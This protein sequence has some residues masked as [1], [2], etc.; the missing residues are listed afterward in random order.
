MEC[1]ST[2]LKPADHFNTWPGENVFGVG[3]VGEFAG[4]ILTGEMQVLVHLQPPFGAIGHI[5]DETF[6]GNKFA[7]TAL[8]RVAAQ[9]RFSDEDIRYGHLENYKRDWVK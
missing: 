6:V 4:Q 9:L 1:S 8:T 5:V 2:G 7:R 3:R